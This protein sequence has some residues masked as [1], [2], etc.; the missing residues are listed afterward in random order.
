MPLEMSES[1]NPLALPEGHPC[2]SAF[3]SP[4]C[5]GH[6]PSHSSLREGPFSCRDVLLVCFSGFDNK[7]SL[8]YLLEDKREGECPW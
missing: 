8:G 5:R 7:F 6:I 2:P 3:S 1:G 4:Y